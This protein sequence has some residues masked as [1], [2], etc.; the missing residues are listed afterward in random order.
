MRKS[1][2]NSRRN[3]M[4]EMDLSNVDCTAFNASI[5]PAVKSML[6]ILDEKCGSIIS[7]FT[8]PNR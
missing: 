4:N 6:Q 7:T 1:D 2:D 5:K 3:G 8:E